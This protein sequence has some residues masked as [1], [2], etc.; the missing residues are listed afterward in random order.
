MACTKKYLCDTCTI[1]ECGMW[2]RKARCEKYV[3]RRVRLIY[4]DDYRAV[5]P[6]T[7]GTVAGVDDIGNIL[8]IWDTGS[9]LHLIPGVDTFK[10]LT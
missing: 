8:V 7:E 4:M 2:P 9:T 1:S 5:P 3:G 10:Y 6:G